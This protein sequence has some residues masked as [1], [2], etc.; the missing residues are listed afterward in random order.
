MSARR[1][2]EKEIR[3]GNHRQGAVV[4][5]SERKRNW[6]MSRE[7]YSNAGV[8]ASRKEAKKKKKSKGFLV[9]E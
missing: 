6:E 1:L 9:I 2:V 7:L 4:L 3:Q 8:V 5:L